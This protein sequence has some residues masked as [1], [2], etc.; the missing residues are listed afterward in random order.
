MAEPTRSERN[1]TNILLRIRWSE[2]QRVETL[3]GKN[4]KELSLESL[5]FMLM[6]KDSFCCLQFSASKGE[7]F[8]EV[9]SKFCKNQSHA[10]EELRM[11]QRKDQ[12]FANFLQV[13]RSLIK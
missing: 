7:E 8:K 2:L 3:R 6:W 13:R 1:R 5:L 12:K 4:E 9:L 11:K 10:L